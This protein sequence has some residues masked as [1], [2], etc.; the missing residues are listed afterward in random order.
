ME[1]WVDV[2]NGFYEVSDR[3]NI[4]RAKPG[5]STFVGR[6]VTPMAS[7]SGYKQVQLSDGI[8][9]KKY[10]VHALVMLAFVGPRA[11]GIVIN[12]KDLD[13][14]NNS[15]DNLEYVTQKQNCA[16]SFI[17][18][19]RKRGPRKPKS[20][21]KGK[22]SGDT[23]WSKRMP[24]RIARGAKMPHS[25]I[26]AEMVASARSRVA[27]G[28]TQSSIAKEYGISVAQMSRIIRGTRWTYV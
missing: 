25:K 19:G 5:I 7:G 17:A 18:Q 8:S 14:S 3:G 11:K 12:H 13:K 15:L 26:T 27:L 10:Y 24:E 2:F 4:R 28:E 1:T 9:S 22:Q 16:H 20:P 6:P 21:P 23:H